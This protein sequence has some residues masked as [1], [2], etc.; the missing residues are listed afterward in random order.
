ME[1]IAK[2]MKENPYT[3]T[4]AAEPHESYAPSNYAWPVY[5]AEPP[6][7]QHLRREHTEYRDNYQA[8]EIEKVLSLALYHLNT[9]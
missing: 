8:W 7:I 5:E 4:P 2:A 3:Q 9:L 6:R 1:D